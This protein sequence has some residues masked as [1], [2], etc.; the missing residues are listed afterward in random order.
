VIAQEHLTVPV[1]YA[2]HDGDTQVR[3]PD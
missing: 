1:W 3:Q 2:G